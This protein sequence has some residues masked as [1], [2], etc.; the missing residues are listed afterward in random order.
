MRSGTG[1]LLGIAFAAATPAWAQQQ[2]PDAPPQVETT[3]VKLEPVTAESQFV[4]T[5]QAIQQVN[6]VA[7][8]EGF[9]DEVAFTEG[10]FVKAGDIVFRIEKDT[11]QAALESAQ[12]TEQAAVAAEAGAQANL[13]EAELS[14]ERQKALLKSA[15]VSQA[16]V[17]Q[18]QAQRDASDAQVKQAQAQ[19]AQA[20][21]QVRTAELNLSFT[22][23]ITPISGRIGRAQVTEGNLVS[24]STGTLATVVQ[25]DPIRVAFSISDRDYLK[26]VEILKPND[27]NITTTPGEF[28]PRLILPDGTTYSEPGKMSFIDNVIDQSTGTIAV[29]AEFPNPH[30]QLVPGQFVTITVD[31]GEPKTLPVI[32]AAAVQRDQEG[33]YVLTLDQENRAVIRRVTLGQRVGVNWAVTAGLAPGEVVIVSGIQRVTPGVVV[34]PKPAPSTEAPASSPD[35]APASGN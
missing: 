26:V 24:P 8:V 15:T 22:D 18:A 27:E 23:I 9:L 7:R 21:A 1:L 19:I 4:G 33:P 2:A 16:V 34:S 10:S 3:A 20:Q 6:L 11:Y 29:Y 28:R 31:A 13:K 35:A 25:T 32:P 14:L 30:L 17:D 5:V 12:A